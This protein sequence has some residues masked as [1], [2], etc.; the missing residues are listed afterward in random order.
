MTVNGF[1]KH[2]VSR[3]FVRLIFSGSK[4]NFPT[5][6]V[7]HVPFLLF[8]I[9]V[10]KASCTSLGHFYFIYECGGPIR[11][12]NIPEVDEQELCIGRLCNMSKDCV[13]RIQGYGLSV[14]VILWMC[15]FH[16]RYL[17][18]LTPSSSSSVVQ[19]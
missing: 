14:A 3:L 2:S 19:I 11:M 18:L 8:I 12:M 9:I 1:V 4:F 13:L 6:S 17:V 7:I 15:L 16:V 5:I 10:T